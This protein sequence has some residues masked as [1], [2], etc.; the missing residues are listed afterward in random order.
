[1]HPLTATLLAAV[2][3]IPF[4]ATC[5]G[6]VDTKPTICVTTFSDFDRKDPAR[7]VWLHA[8]G[9]LDYRGGQWVTAGGRVVGLAAAEDDRI[10]ALEVP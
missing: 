1:M 3:F 6:H 10:C 9:P 7:D 4:A 2:G 8:F 5:A